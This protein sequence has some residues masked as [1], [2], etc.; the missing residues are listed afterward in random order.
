MEYTWQHLRKLLISQKCELQDSPYLFALLLTCAGAGTE[1][2]IKSHPHLCSSAWAWLEACWSY[3]GCYGHCHPKKYCGKYCIYLLS[4]PVQS[5]L[6]KKNKKNLQLLWGGLLFFLNI[7]LVVGAV[8]K[9]ER[10]ASAKWNWRALFYLTIIFTSKRTS[11]KI[12]GRRT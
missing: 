2:E 6:K 9:N 7:I 3:Q 1:E 10:R 8:I 12:N 5:Y 11:Y 4:N